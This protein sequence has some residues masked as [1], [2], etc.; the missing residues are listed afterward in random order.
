MTEAK[1]QIIAESEHPLHIYIGEA[2]V[3]G[4]FGREFGS[5]KFS[6]D[7]LQRQLTKDGYGAQAKN[8]REIGIALEL[9]GVKK[10]R[11]TVGDQKARL[12]VLPDVGTR[13]PEASDAPF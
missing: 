2:V 13:D 11:R 1:K 9:A 3:S 10:I 12:Y 6:F 5:N 4:H 7:E 8:T